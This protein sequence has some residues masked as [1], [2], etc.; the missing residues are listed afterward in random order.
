MCKAFFNTCFQSFESVPSSEIAGSWGNSISLFETTKLFSTAATPI[1]SP[2][3]S[4]QGLQFLHT[5]D[6][7]Y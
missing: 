7:T 5:P 3:N 6:N 2:T 1:Y 4:A